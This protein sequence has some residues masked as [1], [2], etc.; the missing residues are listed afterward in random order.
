[1]KVGDYFLA[2]RGYDRETMDPV[3]GLSYKINS[4]E[5]TQKN[6]VNPTPER[7]AK[8]P[9]RALGEMIVLDVTPTSAT[10]MITLSLEII[11]VGD[12]VELEGPGAPPPSQH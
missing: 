12:Y 1:V 3:D 8:L 5:D 10:A 9:V 2:I 4:M 7:L 6:V 11:N